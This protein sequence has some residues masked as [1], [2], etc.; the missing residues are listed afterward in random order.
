MDVEDKYY[1]KSREPKVKVVYQMH[2]EGKPASH[3]QGINVISIF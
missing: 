2:R 1:D 3:R